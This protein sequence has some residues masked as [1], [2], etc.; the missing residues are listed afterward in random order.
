MKQHSLGIHKLIKPDGTWSEGVELDQFLVSHFCNLYKDR[1]IN[2]SAVDS[3]LSHSPHSISPAQ[4][5]SLTRP[6]DALE[7]FGV[8]SAMADSSAPGP[9][10]FT[11]KFF[12]QCW[13]LL[14]QDLVDACND[15]L[16][17][18]A[19]PKALGA[20]WLCLIPKSP[21]ASSPNDFRPIALCNVGSK[22]FTKLLFSRLAPLL[23][24]LISAEQSAFVKGRNIT[25]NLLLVQEMLTRINRRR[26]DRNLLLKIDFKSAFD[27][28]NWDF[29]RCPSG[30]WLQ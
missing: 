25:D 24:G 13:L 27:S 22:L 11:V 8:L 3:I 10:G 5:A 15:F 6:T 12:K 23:P 16:S 14:A 30:P 21:A 17:G 20:A 29:L 2:N 18:T 4:N 19:I 28:V 1:P 9:D 26:K 7:L